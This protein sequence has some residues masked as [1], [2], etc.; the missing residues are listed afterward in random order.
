MLPEIEP[1]ETPL[2]AEGNEVDLVRRFEAVDDRQDTVAAASGALLRFSRFKPKGIEIWRQQI[3][4]AAQEHQAQRLLGLFYVANDVLLFPDDNWPEYFFK[5]IATS[6]EAAATSCQRSGQSHVL[7]R[8]ARLPGIWRNRQVFHPGLCDELAALFGAY[9]HTNQAA[10]PQQAH[11]HGHDALQSPA[12]EASH[13]SIVSSP[14]QSPQPISSPSSPPTSMD[15]GREWSHGEPMEGPESEGDNSIAET[16]TGGDARC[17]HKASTEDLG[18]DANR[19]RRADDSSEVHDRTPHGRM[20]R[21]ARPRPQET[22]AARDDGSRGSRESQSNQPD[23]W[24][25]PGERRLCGVGMSLAPKHPARHEEL[26]VKSLKEG[27]PLADVRE[28]RAGDLLLSVDGRDCRGV[29]RDVVREWVLGK[30]GTRVRLVF[31]ALEGSRRIAVTLARAF[32]VVVKER[33]HELEL[34]GK[35]YGEERHGSGCA[36]P[37][38]EERREE[39]RERVD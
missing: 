12:P 1:A 9:M 22:T 27:G 17:L 15:S 21:T 33:Q 30:A 23:D 35:G 6:L 11:S 2:G 25:G 20:P 19:K 13:G 28:V 24:A 4:H 37:A 34:R 26:Y 31:K 29:S 14:S 8:M 16:M 7:A 32:D 10:V 36:G 18:L 5:C 3:Y 38:R 39:R